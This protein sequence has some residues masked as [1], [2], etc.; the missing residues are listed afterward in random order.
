MSNLATFVESRLP[1][2]S[3]VFKVCAE[4]PKTAKARREKQHAFK[5][6]FYYGAA[7]FMPWDPYVSDCAIQTA[8]EL[9]I[10][11]G[12]W[13]SLWEQRDKIDN[14]QKIF[15]LEHIYTFSMCWN[16]TQ[17]L[18]QNG[19]MTKEAVLENLE[20]NYAVAWITRTENAILGRRNRGTTLADALKF[21]A[22]NKVI[23]KRASQRR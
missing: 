9:N 19:K 5:H 15:F 18:W 20:K 13:E 21:Y 17:G 22:E 4:E 3:H 10:L 8:G 11:G 1:M 6:D 7:Y 14:G 12:W 23:I 16:A 2:L